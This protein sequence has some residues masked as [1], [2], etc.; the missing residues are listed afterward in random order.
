MQR[1]KTLFAAAGILLVAWTSP[2]MAECT[3]DQFVAVRGGYGTGETLAAYTDTEMA[4]F[5]S[6][7][8][9]GV[10][11]APLLNAPEACVDQAVRCLDGLH[12]THLAA[13]LRRYLDDHSEEWD[14]EAHLL[15]YRAIFGPC[16]FPE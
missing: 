7:F 11:V 6:A 12:D 16:M 2:A 13:I 15:A 10:V 14:E 5:A 8:A 4:I 9:N 3:L 1:M